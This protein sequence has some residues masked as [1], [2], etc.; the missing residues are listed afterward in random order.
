MKKQT[1][2]ISFKRYVLFQSDNGGKN[3]RPDLA[4]D[5]ISECIEQSAILEQRGKLWFVCTNDL[6]A[7]RWHK[8]LNG[9]MFDRFKETMKGS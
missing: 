1:K 3:F 6:T 8:D 5:I 4:S 2:K 7:M 9:K